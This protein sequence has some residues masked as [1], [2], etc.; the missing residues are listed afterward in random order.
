LKTGIAAFDILCRARLAGS[1]SEARRLIKAGGARLND[2]VIG[3]ETQTIGTADLDPDG[4]IK[5]SAGKKR[6]ALVRVV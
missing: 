2:T 5:L 6:H 1:K 4:L 3:A